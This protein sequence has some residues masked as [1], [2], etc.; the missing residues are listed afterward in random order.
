MFN[1]VIFGP[2]GSGKGT[3]SNWIIEKYNLIHLSTGDVLRTEIKS[4]SE[5]GQEIKKL[6][7]HGNLVPDEMIEKMVK[8]FVYDNKDS[9]GIIFDGFPRTTAQGLWLDKTLAEINQEVSIFLTLE[10]NNIE[11]KNRILKRGKDSQRADDQDPAIIDNR[12]KVYNETTKP[13]I[14]YFKGQDK[15]YPI[16]GLGTQQEVFANVCYAI[17]QIKKKK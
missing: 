5:L 16:H 4:G 15:Y 6:I 1:I 3:Q 10:V 17:S 2:P 12:I 7:D 11:L 8:K 14:H 13:V 9:N